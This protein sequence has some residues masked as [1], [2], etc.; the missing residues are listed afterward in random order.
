MRLQAY[1]SGEFGLGQ[2]LRPTAFFDSQGGFGKGF[3]LLFCGC[4]GRNIIIFFVFIQNKICSFGT[5]IKV[6]AYAKISNQVK[7]DDK[8]IQGLTDQLLADIKIAAFKK[9]HKQKTKARI[10]S[11]VLGDDFCKDMYTILVSAY[12][13][14]IPRFLN[15]LRKNQRNRCRK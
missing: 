1:L 10:I 12:A 15:P 5:M 2:S 11:R 4:H 13:I 8:L 7:N 3:C 14:R 6:A 9:S